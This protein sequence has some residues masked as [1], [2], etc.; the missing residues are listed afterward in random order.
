MTL[1]SSISKLTTSVDQLAGEANVTKAQLYAK[2]A[3]ADAAVVA[4]QAEHAATEAARDEAATHAA[5]AAT[6]LA[7]VKADVTYQ[8]IGA[9]LA[10][11]A[12]TAVDVFVYDTG[13]DSDGGAWR[14]RCQHT[15]W[16]NEPLNTATRGARREFPAVAVLVA[17]ADKVTIYDGDDPALPMWMVFEENGS[18]LHTYWLTG[19]NA[20]C[21]FALN[22]QLLMGSNGDTW[23]GLRSCD[24]IGDRLS[25]RSA[26]SFFG[27][28][29][30]V[31]RTINAALATI[32]NETA[33][34]LVNFVVN[35]VAMSVLSDA[36]IDAVT[37]LPAP[38]IAVATDGGISLIRHDG[39]V[40]NGSTSGTWDNIAIYGEDLFAQITSTTLTWRFFGDIRNLAPGFGEKRTYF[41]WVPR[42]A[43]YPPVAW[44]TDAKSVITG[45]KELSFGSAGSAAGLYRLLDNDLADASAKIQAAVARITTS[46]TTGWLHGAVKGAFLADTADTDL[47]GGLQFHSDPTCDSTST[48]AVP[49]P[50]WSYTADVADVNLTTPGKLHIK[51]GTSGSVENVSGIIPAGIAVAVTFTI[52]NSTVNF[53]IRCVLRGNGVNYFAEG[54]AYFGAD[55]VYTVYFPADVVT[56]DCYAA[57]YR[58][59]SHS[60][61]LDIDDISVV[62]ADADRSTND[63]GLIVNGTITRSPVADGAELVGYSGFST[64]NYLEQSYNPDLDFGTGDFCVMGWSKTL[65]N[66]YN[67]L[68]TISHLYNDGSGANGWELFSTASDA[69]FRLRV[70]GGIADYGVLFPASPLDVWTHW[71]IIRT[72]RIMQAYVNGVLTGTRNLSPLAFDVT[73]NPL[74][75]LRVNSPIGGKSH[76]LL[77]ISAA[78]P[79]A[80]QIAKIYEDER[81]LFQPGAACTLFGTSDAVTALA[82]DPK[83]NLLHVGTSQGRS[84]FDGLVRV[85]N[86]ETPVTTAIS[87]VGGMI[88]E[89]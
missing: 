56:A 64:T 61:T 69:R 42:T 19:R 80:D 43:Y 20:S 24:F 66:V 21:V 3:Q 78:A 39:T 33:L 82:H 72:G 79:T 41:R 75:T 77:R 5:S 57:F 2:A 86:T 65:S 44:N 50:D 9:I 16:Y 46:H 47:V 35:D 83:T 15:S 68:P 8:G 74:R 84:V 87:A 1:M 45:E 85:A 22:G 30:V 34:R 70:N 55:G 32:S 54:G 58:F 17:E 14:K 28:R 31:E 7:T 73:A 88:A 51:E 40:V 67:V 52:S 71:T 12:V 6:H 60:G 36:P 29:P 18:T 4:T 10:E 37:G 25:R 59:G 48:F 49:G 81:R 23:G 38:T 89:Q 76:A 11:K 13:L 27:Y 53:G 63:R 62:S 26:V